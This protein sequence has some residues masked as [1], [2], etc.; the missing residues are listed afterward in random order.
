MLFRACKTTSQPSGNLSKRFL[1]A[2]R[3]SLFTRLRTTAPP[4][5]RPTARP[6]RVGPST[7]QQTAEKKAFAE[8]APSLYTRSNSLRFKRRRDFGKLRSRVE[9]RLD[10]LFLRTNCEHMPTLGPPGRKY[11]SA[12]GA[13][14]TRP[15]PV[16][17]GP[18]AAVWLKSSFRHLTSSVTC[19]A[20][21][22]SHQSR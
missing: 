17:L 3:K 6:T 8:R 22:L 10:R 18:T 7:S 19:P 13:L 15:K 2:S 4:T 14:H 1:T 20:Q 9:P 16:L 12:C 11:P 5:E 21:S